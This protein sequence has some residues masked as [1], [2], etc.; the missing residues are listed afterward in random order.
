VEA[1]QHSV[2]LYLL[3]YKRPGGRQFGG[4]SAGVWC[5][6]RSFA[7]TNTTHPAAEAGQR[8][9]CPDLVAAAADLSGWSNRRGS[10]RPAAT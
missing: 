8:E 1:H 6:R 7:T 5:G 10:T 9:G 4:D 2:L 3:T